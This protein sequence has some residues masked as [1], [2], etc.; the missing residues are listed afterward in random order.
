MLIIFSHRVRISKML[1]LFK[2][3]EL[4]N[5]E[6]ITHVPQ[7]VLL[8]ILD[9]YGI[10]PIKEGNAVFYADSPNIESYQK[11]YPKALLHTAGNEVGL[12]YGE[13]GNSEV[14]H[15][16]IGAGRIVYQALLRVSNEIEAGKLYDNKVLDELKKHVKKN[17]SALHLIGLLSA[18]GSHSHIEHLFALIEW[19]AKNNL[20]NVFL[21]LFTDGRDSPPTSGEYFIEDL[22][23][24]IKEFKSNAKIASLG[25]RYFGMDRDKHWERLKKSYLTM[26][27]QSRNKESDPIKVLSENYQK[28]ITDE[29]IEPVMF[30]D[31]SGEPLAKISDDDGILFFNIRPDR[32]REILSAFLN[33]KFNGFKTK[34]F[35]NLFI[36]TLTEY[37]H[38]KGVKVIF[39][40]KELTNTLGEV[41]SK[42][43]LK[44]FRIAETEKYAHV[45]YFFN[46]GREKPFIGETRVIIQ[47]PH[48]PTF[49]K[50]PEMSAYKITQ[51]VLAELNLGRQDFYVI[52]FANP[53][54]VGHTGNFKAIVKG[55]EVVDECLGLI[56]KKILALD[57]LAIITSDHGNAE[58]T[59][60]SETGEIDTEHNIYPAPIILVA[61]EL[62][63]K[64][65]TKSFK[66]L[67]VEPIGALCD[68][69][70]T[71][72]DLMDIKQP[73]EMT[74]I[75][76]LN[77]LK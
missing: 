29:F 28:N 45:T 50:K 11:K 41:L 57:G 54:L 34:K 58:V 1:N 18:G 71:I 25:G 19:A 67:L 76:L 53:D 39:P 38:Y 47:S 2:K 14:G 48:V 62:E 20:K 23:R 7:P 59:K 37:D 27:G 43:G 40:E 30:C 21:H 10:S 51:K 69:A 17:K 66:E 64:K 75:S 8:I 70:P 72:L 49:D 55:I 13:F 56:V 3:P 65:P 44:Q 63:N 31:Q 42:K 73:E 6:K 12:P 61:K 60:N 9:G 74:G 16:N 52:N 36:A 32:T 46:G 77:S 68:I 5:K 26:I 35:K 22:Q 4:S 24:R 33:E 15:L